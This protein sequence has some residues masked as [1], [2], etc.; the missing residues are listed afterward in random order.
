MYDIL[1]DT[2]APKV[3]ILKVKIWRQYWW[4][5]V[6]SDAM[7]TFPELFNSNNGKV[8][9]DVIL[10]LS[11]SHYLCTSVFPFLSEG[12]G[13]GCYHVCLWP[14]GS[15]NLMAFCR[16]GRACHGHHNT[17]LNTVYLSILALHTRIYRYI[18]NH[19]KVNVLSACYVG[20]EQH[21]ARN[22]QL[23][24]HTM[25][26]HQLFYRSR[27]ISG[28]TDSSSCTYHHDTNTVTKFQLHTCQYFP[29]DDSTRILTLWTMKLTQTPLNFQLLYWK[30]CVIFSEVESQVFRK[31]AYRV[32]V[33]R[34]EGRRPLG[35]PSHTWEDNIK[36]DLKY[37]G[38]GGPWTGL[39]WLKIATGSRRLWM[40]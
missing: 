5:C 10:Q 33:G 15:R 22:Y 23:Q 13:G 3:T 31:G 40:R 7:L 27:V 16:T 14:A 35:R 36:I 28:R 17:V 18:H 12:G 9:T 29:A 25:R 11:H 20:F 6:S 19:S 39:I 8:H 30:H 1:P 24:L 26:I 21:L 38:L 34:P 4:C 37:V 32:L 2:T